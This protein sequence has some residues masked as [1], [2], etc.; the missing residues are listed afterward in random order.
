MSVLKATDTHHSQGNTVL[1]DTLR[2]GLCVVCFKTSQTPEPSHPSERPDPF[3]KQ[4]SAY[5]STFKF[6]SLPRQLGKQRFDLSFA[7][8]IRENLPSG[9]KGWECC[10]AHCYSSLYYC[11]YSLVLSSQPIYLAGIWLFTCT[12]SEGTASALCRTA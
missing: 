5:T 12:K 8:N 1:H 11:H 6:F 3:P 2:K 7:T 10:V 4:T 9:G